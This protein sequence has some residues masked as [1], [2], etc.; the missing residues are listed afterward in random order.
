MVMPCATVSPGHEVVIP[1]N[2]VQQINYLKISNLYGRK[3]II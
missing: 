3:A 1:E 2:N